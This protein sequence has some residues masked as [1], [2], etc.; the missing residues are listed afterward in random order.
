MHI[1]EE[2]KFVLPYCG[3]RV[4]LNAK[5]LQSSDLVQIGD[6]FVTLKNDKSKKMKAHAKRLQAGWIWRRNR[7][8]GHNTGHKSEWQRYPCLYSLWMAGLHINDRQPIEHEQIARLIEGARQYA[9]Y[10][11]RLHKIRPHDLELFVNEFSASV[12][13][14]ST[15]RAPRKVVARARFAESASTARAKHLTDSSG[16]SNPMAVAMQVGA[17][18]GHLQEREQDVIRIGANLDARTLQ[19]FMLIQERIRLYWD[20]WCFIHDGPINYQSGTKLGIT[21]PEKQAPSL[22]EI[23]ANEGHSAAMTRLSILNVQLLG[24]SE[25]PFVNNARHLCADLAWAIVSTDPAIRGHYLQKARDGMLWIFACHF[26][27]MFFLAPLSML[28]HD[29]ESA[30]RALRRESGEKD[31]V[32]M[33]TKSLAPDEFEHLEKALA[34]FEK[35]LGKCSDELLERKM[36]P[37]TIKVLRLIHQKIQANDWRAVKKLASKMAQIF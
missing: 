16:K 25:R 37:R 19:V 20:L 23:I 1:S 21:L 14:L 9:N 18:I 35:R 22:S 31:K 15:K 4:A 32:L 13:E 8:M 17:G 33:I 28:I 7:Q 12:Q 3:A 24:V 27:W 36:K 11:V 6:K 30:M 34:E 2:K 26:W 5:Y 29:L 10:L